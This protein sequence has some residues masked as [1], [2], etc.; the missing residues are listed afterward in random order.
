MIGPVVVNADLRDLPV[1]PPGP[2]IVRPLL[3]PGLHGTGA[4]TESEE[5]SAFPQFQSL[6]GKIFR[7]VP[8]MPPPLLTFDGIS[9]ADS[10]CGCE[11]PDTIGDVGPNHYVETTN[12]A[13]KIFDKSGNVLLAAVS[14]DTFFAPLGGT[15]PCG[16]GLNQGD[17]YSFYDHVAD[18]WVVSDFAFVSFGGNPSYECVA[19][20]QTSDPVAGGWFLYAVLVDPTD[21]NDYPKA[22]MWNNPTPGGAYHFTYNMW[23]SLAGPFTGVKVQALDRAAMLAGTPNPTVVTFKI[24]LAGLP[25]AAY[26]LVAA[27][28]RT[29]D[30]PPAGRDEMLLAIRS[31]NTAP[32]TFSD[33]LGWLFHV[34]F[35]TPANSTLGIGTDHTANAFM[36]VNTYTEAWTGTTGFSLVPQQGTASKLDTLGDKIMTPVVYQNRNGTE[37]LWADQTTILNYPNGPTAVSW[38]QFDV[39]SGTFPAAAAQQQ[40]W[41]NGGDGLWRFMPSIAVDQNG[42]AAI[43]YATSSASIH[44]GMRYAGRLETDPPNNLGQGEAVMFEGA[45]SQNGNRWGDYSMTTIDT[46]GMTFWHAN[47]YYATTGNFSWKT[48]IGKFNFQ[49]GGVSPTPTPTA[50]PASCS[51]AA[52]PDL[53]SVGTRIVGVFF[54]ANGKFYGMGGRSSDTAGNEFTHP[55]EYDPGTNAWTTKSA[56]YPDIQVNNMACGVLT[57]AG[58]DYIYCVGGSD[59]ASQTTTGRV[60]RYDPVTDSITTVAAPWPG[61]GANAVLP[62]GFTVFQN[63]FY[64]L[65]GF[66]IPAGNG[67]NQIWEFTPSLAAWVQKAAVLPVPLGYIPT[68]TI[69][70]LIFTGGGSDITGG[71]LTDTTNSFVYNPVADTIGTIASIPRA[72]GETRA[73]NFCNNMYVMG[74]GRTNPPNPSN[75]VDVYDP[76]AGTWSL[77]QPFVNARRNFPTDTDGTNRIWLAGG[78]DAGGAIISSMEI[79]N[80]PVSPCGPP[81]SP[82]PTATATAT[83]TPTATPAPPRSSPTPRPRPTPAPRP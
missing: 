81:P 18:R 53:P 44:P 12:V 33:V 47:E 58:T 15:T 68:T 40:E 22:A 73:L 42:N 20:S 3:K 11:P 49:G 74:G 13:I 72:T 19:V 65:G 34:D 57:D 24:P 32:A 70:T 16:T 17:P 31:G 41:T 62:G 80:C 5:T 28:F 38:Y 29:G 30:P 6:L 56:T 7:P 60:F 82:T 4:R 78:Y 37:S 83:A 61:A 54:P 77:G 69:G 23:A 26:S 66:D 25:D 27:G 50:T 46:D 43:G 2:K 1:V 67:T 10:F 76:V 48:R 64:I 59:V 36:S 63:K 14:Y 75:E 35:V 21:A 51:W 45:G 9:S 39:T 52:G 79:F 8:N 55:F 71:L